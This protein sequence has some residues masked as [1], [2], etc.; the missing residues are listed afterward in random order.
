MEDTC[1]KDLMVPISEYAAVTVGTSLLDAI[2]ALEK[3]QE[4]YTSSKYQ[5][6]AILVLD[7]D[8]RVVGRVSQLRVLQAVETR[9]D[10]DSDLEKLSN[11][12]FSEEYIAGRREYY[13]LNG[14][15][16]NSESLLAASEKKVESF[17]QK[18]TPGEFVSE[19]SSIDIA[20]HKLVAGAHSSL[21]VTREDVIVGV[22]RI[23]DVFSAVFHEMRDAGMTPG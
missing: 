6:R 23:P 21:L 19:D 10:L 14:P 5:H 15:V 8:R 12:R 9:Y 22:L 16:L 11:F 20:I 4:A 7:S 13:R 2:L 18:P 17:M 1:V 3:A